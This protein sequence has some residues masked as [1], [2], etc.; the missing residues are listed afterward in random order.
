MGG[1]GFTKVAGR[2]LQLSINAGLGC[3]EAALLTR[4]SAVER[5]MFPV[6]NH[7][8]CHVKGPALHSAN[9]H[10]ASLGRDETAS[11]EKD[12]QGMKV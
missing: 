4:V 12:Q 1:P 6:R 9:H 2:W 8:I 11:C 3:S 5:H 7:G 10:A